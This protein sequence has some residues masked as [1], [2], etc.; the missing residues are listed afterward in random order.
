MNC[1]DCDERM[2]IKEIPYFYQDLIYLGDFEAKI[3]TKCGSFYF[4]EESSKEIE[5]RAQLI[6]IWGRKAIP[7]GKPS[8]SISTR[9][10]PKT[11]ASIIFGDRPSP[12]YKIDK[13]VSV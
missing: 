2:V 1:P 5:L 11:K 7:S 3:C 12:L 4:T 8:L 10:M 9:G 13:S 6:G